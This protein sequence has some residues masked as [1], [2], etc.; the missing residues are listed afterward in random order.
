[1][2]NAIQNCV[3]NLSG[4]SVGSNSHPGDPY[5]HA[6][7]T[8]QELI[9]TQQQ[10]ANSRQVDQRAGF[11]Q[12]QDPAKVLGS[13]SAEELGIEQFE[14]DRPPTAQRRPQPPPPPAKPK[15]NGWLM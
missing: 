7:R 13:E 11:R 8:R 3:E 14:D 4:T 12:L 9:D 15:S 1:M 6:A 5:S 10:V 2:A